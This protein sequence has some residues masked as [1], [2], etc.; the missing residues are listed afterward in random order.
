[1]N[2]EFRPDKGPQD[3]YCVCGLHKSHSDHSE[4]APVRPGYVEYDASS[5]IPELIHRIE[6]VLSEA[7][8][9]AQCKG[10][11]QPIY[12]IQGKPNKIAYNMDGTSHFGTCTRQHEFVKAGAPK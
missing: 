7:G 8:R 5:T 3:P 1:M 11:F 4:V 9:F 2:H 6:N 12:W 10:C